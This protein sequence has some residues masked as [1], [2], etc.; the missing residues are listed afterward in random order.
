MHTYLVEIP[1]PVEITAESRRALKSAIAAAVRGV[2][3]T[4]A[5]VTIDHLAPPVDVQQRAVLD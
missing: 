2:L 5:P 4:G 1:E 3:F